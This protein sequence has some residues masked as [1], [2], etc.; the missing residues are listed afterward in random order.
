MVATSLPVDTE[1]A[2]AFGELPPGRNRQA[3]H[4]GGEARFSAGSVTGVVEDNRS[5]PFQAA[6][7]V[8]ISCVRLEAE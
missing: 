6:T 4:A 2:D 7:C 5:Q 3:R 8:L 1:N